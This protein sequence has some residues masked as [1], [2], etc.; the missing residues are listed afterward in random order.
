[1]N[2]K[3]IKEYESC[4]NAKNR[5]HEKQSITCKRHLNRKTATSKQ[6]EE[7]KLKLKIIE[8]AIEEIRKGIAKE[9]LSS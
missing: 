8:R 3:I 4:A 5:Q 2:E 6:K 1:M 9:R 7:K